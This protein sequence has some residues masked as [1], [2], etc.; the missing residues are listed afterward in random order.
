MN[1]G[2]TEM[3]SILGKNSVDVK[4]LTNNVEYQQTMKKNGLQSVCTDNE[5]LIHSLIDN[6][7]SQFVSKPDLIILAHSLPYLLGSTNW[8]TYKRNI[9]VINM[10]GIPC[11]I[12]HQAIDSAVK[13][14]ES[15]H[16]QHVLV[17]GADK[18]YIDYE[19]LF[20]GTA[21]SD[22]VIG[23][24]VE[25]NAK[26]NIIRGTKVN[27]FIIASNGVYS[28]PESTAKFRAG[29][30]T[31]VRNVLLDCLKEQNY[32]L[33]DLDYIV[34]HTSNRGIWDQVSQ[35]LRYPRE[36]FLDS[37]IIKTG[38]MNSNDSFYHYFDFV[39]RGILKEG[40][41]AA[42]INPGFGGSQGC[43]LLMP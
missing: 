33:N 10:S 30:P 11:C 22:C 18:C 26:R 16:Y 31:F 43:T 32:S 34:C 37:N 9:P 19:R 39:D 1:I 23:L 7:I 13:Y 42:L 36:K 8:N 6:I 15:G 17:I 35:L 38:H 5:C 25:N 12:L 2:I 29:N 28:S 27:T 21:M 41:L 3:H 14:I 40:Q 24:M 20:F 4:S